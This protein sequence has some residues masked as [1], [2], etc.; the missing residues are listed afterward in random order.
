M[1]VLLRRSVVMN[2]ASVA[3]G[4]RVKFLSN[5][6]G[7]YFGRTTPADQGGTMPFTRA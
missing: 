7:S 4:E 6:D 5:L 2:W 3:F 1:S